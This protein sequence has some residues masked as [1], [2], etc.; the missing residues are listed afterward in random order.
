MAMTEALKRAQKKYNL[1]V[2]G[3]ARAKKYNQSDCGKLAHKTYSISKKG[4]LAQATADLKY[5]KKTGDYFREFK[6]KQWLFKI[7][8]Y[9]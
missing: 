8:N 4:K 2:K 9:L 6:A 5:A 3:K 7:N 1:T